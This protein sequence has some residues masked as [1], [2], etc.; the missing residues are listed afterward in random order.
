MPIRPNWLRSRRLWGW[1][2]ALCVTALVVMGA[3]AWVFSEN[4]PLSGIGRPSAGP[5]HPIESRHVRHLQSNG[6]SVAI[7]SG[8]Y[9]IGF[10]WIV[11][12]WFDFHGSDETCVIEPLGEVMPVTT[13]DFQNY[14]VNGTDETSVFATVQVPSRGRFSCT[15]RAGRLLDLTLVRLS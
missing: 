13:T 9:G 4:G 5:V 11:D 15:D 10:G 1:V 12:T 2:L 8:S 7:P 6:V 14:R 3:G